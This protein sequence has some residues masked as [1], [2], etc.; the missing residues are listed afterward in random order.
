MGDYTRYIKAH[1]EGRDDDG[2]RQVSCPHDFT[3]QQ[4]RTGSLGQLWGGGG[5]VMWE[6]CLSPAQ[7][8]VGLGS[9]A[10]AGVLGMVVLRRAPERERER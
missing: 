10:E 5:Q 3:E 2:P 7:H 6:G 9:C 1:C 8:L 4:F